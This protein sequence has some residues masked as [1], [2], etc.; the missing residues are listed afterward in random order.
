MTKRLLVIISDRL[1]D[2]IR[3]GEMTPRY[4]N[5]G[6]LF[7]EVH[8]LMTNNDHPDPGMLQRTVGGAKLSIYNLPADKRLFIRSLGWQTFLMK[9]WIEE[10]LKIASH[11][12]PHLIRVYNNFK[13]ISRNKPVLIAEQ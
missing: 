6:E 4:Y 3:K 5:P 9:N 13:V 2:L 8:I 7:D 12:S 10:G 11:V 1:S